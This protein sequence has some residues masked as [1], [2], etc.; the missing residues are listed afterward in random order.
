MNGGERGLSNLANLI[1]SIP[2][3]LANLQLPLKPGSQPMQTIQFSDRSSAVYAMDSHLRT[4]YYQNFSFSLA[5]ALN[6]STILEAR[7]VGNAGRKLIQQSN[8]NEVNIVENG[9]LDAY[10]ITQ[11]GGNAPLFDK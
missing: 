1:P 5:R 10:R 9:I 6:Q 11:K 2:T 4:P 7:Y 3:T 8:I